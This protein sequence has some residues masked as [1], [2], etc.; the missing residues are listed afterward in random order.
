MT[1]LRLLALAP[2]VCLTPHVLP[3]HALTPGDVLC[4]DV[5]TIAVHGYTARVRRVPTSERRRVLAAYH[6]R[7]TSREIELDHL[8][9]LELGRS[10]SAANLWPQPIA[11]ARLK[12][13][14][15][16]YLHRT[17]VAGRMGLPDAQRCIAV[18][19]I[20]CWERNGR[21]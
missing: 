17:V 11:E 4:T 19:W 18:D 5:A 1:L 7:G 9:P 13:R 10:N 12:D 20:A 15:E 8:I 14:L 3:D 16:N 2:L 21:P 6:F